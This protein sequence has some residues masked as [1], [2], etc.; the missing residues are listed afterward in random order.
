MDNLERSIKIIRDTYKTKGI[1]GL[2]AGCTAL[3]VGNAA[4]AGIRFVSYD[5]FEHLL[6]DSQVNSCFF[7]VFLSYILHPREKLVPRVV[8]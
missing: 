3:V 8:F 2:Y 4:K 5:H 7:P 6:A 1:T